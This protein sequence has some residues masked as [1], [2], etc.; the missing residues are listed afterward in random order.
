MARGVDA[1][2]EERGLAQEL[3]GGLDDAAGEV[4]RNGKGVIFSLFWCF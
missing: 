2:E 1:V 3:L 4:G